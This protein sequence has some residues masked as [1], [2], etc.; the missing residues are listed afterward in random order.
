MAIEY[1]HVRFNFGLASVVDSTTFDERL[2]S[3]LTE[4]AAGG[5]EMT[6]CFH[7]FGYHAHLIFMRKSQEGPA[8]A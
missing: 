2:M 4:A 6:G 3:V 8:E 7:D 5:W 1:K